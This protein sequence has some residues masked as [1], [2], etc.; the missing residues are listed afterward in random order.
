MV[1][2]RLEVEGKGKEGGRREEIAGKT[3]FFQ[4]AAGW[5]YS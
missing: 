2:R 5:S 4:H 3:F 1:E